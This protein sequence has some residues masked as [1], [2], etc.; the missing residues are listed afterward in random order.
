MSKEE[1]KQKLREKPGYMKSGAPNL[2]RIFGVSKKLARA[3]VREVSYEERTNKDKVIIIN[4]TKTQYQDFLEWQA[5]KN[6]T[7]AIEEEIEDIFYIET[8][9]VKEQEGMHILMGCNHVPF[10]N[11]Q[12]HKGVMQLIEDYN[13]IVKGFHLMGDFLDLN[14]LSSH[15]K[16]KFT[17]IP[18]LTLDSEYESG[19]KLL[20]E[21]EAVLP[22]DCWKTYIYGNHEDRHNRWMSSMDNAK[23]P[24]RSPKE[25][26][27]L[28]ERG[29]L[30]KTS[31][32]QDYITLGNDFDI[33]HGIYFS[34]HNAKAHLDKLRRSCAYVHTH[35][36]Q[37]YREG[38]MA[39]FNIG[40]C[41]DFKS[42]AFNYATR[43]MKQQW[44]NGFA[45]NMIDNKGKSNVTQVNVNEDGH[46]WFGGK[47]Y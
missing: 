3:A 10:E 2:S 1:L 8:P 20:D 17:A 6:A 40:A 46:F 11:K 47:F 41:A 30:V 44:A 28:D 18:G 36:I 14:A 27:N 33:F 15:D 31:W 35:R 24:L 21:F 29:Y 22:E 4:D 19:N 16:G 42:K 43:P 32:S 9:L 5:E 45:I 38:N 23:T 26:L 34:I 37:N 12:L 13:V 25:A 7:E 39:A